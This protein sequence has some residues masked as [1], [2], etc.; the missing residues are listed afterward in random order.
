MGA[1][2]LH[3]LYGI[4]KNSATPSWCLWAC[5]ITAL[6]WLSFHLLI[7]GRSVGVMARPLVLAGQNVFLAYLLSELSPSAIDLLRLDGWYAGL[8]A[9]GLAHAVARSAGCALILLA[10]TIGLNRLGFRLK[11]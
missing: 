10:A 5:A 11:L 1:W 9:P 6:L 3:G 7:D 4:N 2:L 8:A